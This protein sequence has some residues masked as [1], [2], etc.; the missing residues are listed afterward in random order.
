MVTRGDMPLHDGSLIAR[1]P[2]PLLG[3]DS[4]RPH[5]ELAISGVSLARANSWQVLELGSLAWSIQTR[6]KWALWGPWAAQCFYIAFCS[7]LAPEVETSI[8]L[9]SQTRTSKQ[10]LFK[11]TTQNVQF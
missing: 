8:D 2:L 3:E 5:P 4:C 9:S 1:T 6:C 7:K 10:A 11:M